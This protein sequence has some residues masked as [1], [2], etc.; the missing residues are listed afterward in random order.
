MLNEPLPSWLCSLCSF[1]LASLYI[2]SFWQNWGLNS[3]LHA[4]QEGTLPL[5]PHLQSPFTSLFNC[6]PS[7]MILPFPLFSPVMIWYEMYPQKAHVWKDW[8]PAGGAILGGSG[9]F[10]RWD[11]AGGSR[12]L[13]VGTW[14]YFA[15]GPFLSLLLSAKKWR[16]ASATHSHCVGTWGQAAMDRTLWNCEQKEIFPSLTH[17]CQ[18]SGHSNETAKETHL[19]TWISTLLLLF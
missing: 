2:F 18:V 14:G 15:P 6:C 4:C 8:F 1:T 7:H 12:S 13:E 16:T 19:C 9:N 11:L 17:F 3:E 5:E 10:R